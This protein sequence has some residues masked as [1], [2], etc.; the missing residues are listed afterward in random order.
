MR[1]TLPWH[2][3]DLK[4]G[5]LRSM[6]DQAGYIIDDFVKLLEKGDAQSC[7]RRESMI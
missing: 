2:N 5:T 1:V 6:I 4:R 7:V 3:K